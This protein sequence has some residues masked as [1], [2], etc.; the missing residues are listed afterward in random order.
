MKKIIL[1]VV[2]VFTFGFVNAQEKADMAFG[3]KGGLNISTI[4]N[5][6]VDGVNTKSLVGFHVGF[7]G[8]F[9]ISNK[10]AIQPEVLYSAQGTELEFEGISGDLKLDYITIPV[11][12]KYYVADAFSLELGPQIGFLVSAKA[13]SGGESED[14]KDELK[15]TDVSLNF[16]AG[17]DITPN[18]MIGVRY[19]LG[20]TRLQ[21]EIFPGEDESKNSVFQISVGYKF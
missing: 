7:F 19:S 4:T 6:D 1:M 17:Y 8:E 14:V 3:V 18:F 2:M 20:L 12:A 15:S 13:K 9:M 11:M 21:D 5:A 16:G 10:F